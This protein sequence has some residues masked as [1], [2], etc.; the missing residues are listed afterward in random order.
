MAKSKG[1]TIWFSG[2]HGSG[3]TTIADALAAKIR[4]KGVQVVVLDGDNVRKSISA[5]LG[6]SKEDRN[7]HI[8]RVADICKI[9][10]GNNVLNIACVASPTQE[11]RDYAKSIISNFF[12]VYIKCSLEE[13]E[14][15]DVKGHYQKA[16]NK[17][18]GFENFLGVGLK[19]E[20]PK[21]PDI[22]IKTG[23]ESKEESVKKLFKALVEQ[24]WLAL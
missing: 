2:L 12:E 13:C 4:E 16:R 10:S 1:G 18:P 15:R 23:N 11:A 22:V 24:K 19:Y 21:N 14:R 6:Y 7:K 20:E 8:K 5:D 17:E 3:K 9:I